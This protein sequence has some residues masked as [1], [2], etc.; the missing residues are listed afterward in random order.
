MYWRFYLWLSEFDN[1][2]NY[3]RKMKKIVYIL[4]QSA[5]TVFSF[6]YFLIK[7]FDLT[8]RG[9]FLITIKGA[10]DDNKMKYHQILYKTSAFIMNHIP[11]TT[12]SL[13]NKS[14]ET[15]EKP[16]IVIC[17]HQ[18]HLDVMA[19][20]MLTPKLIIL[21]KNWVWNNPF[22]GKIIRYADYFPV[23]ETEKMSESIRAKIEKGYSVLIFPEGTR[24][25]DCRILRFHRGAFYMAE[26]LNMD[27]VPVY[28]DGFGKVLPKKSFHL[29]PGNLTIEV[30]PRIHRD[31]PQ[32]KCDYRL[33]TKRLHAMYLE[34]HNEEMCH[35]R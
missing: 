13:Q 1:K 34:K 21:T 24:S 23:S 18:S 10:T 5:Y 19:L 2:K 8:V 11:G 20:M 35:H 15:F 25:E 22:Y 32:W 26:L 33:M 16:S 27:I 6:C 4:R 12:F 31:D 30:M 28:I 7:A 3:V 29:H 9:F 14:G 17:N